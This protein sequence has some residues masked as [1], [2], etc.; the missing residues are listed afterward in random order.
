MEPEPESEP[1]PVPLAG[2]SA[3]SQNPPNTE[4]NL[5][6]VQFPLYVL[7]LNINKY[8]LAISIAYFTFHVLVLTYA[9]NRDNLTDKDGKTFTTYSSQSDHVS[10]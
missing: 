2:A 1:V 6:K 5:R 9:R 3:W 10:I 8:L 7:Y 4:Q